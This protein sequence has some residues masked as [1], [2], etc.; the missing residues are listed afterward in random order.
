MDGSSGVAAGGGRA[1]VPEGDGSVGSVGVA[2]R[3][4]LPAGAAGVAVVPATGR[5]VMVIVAAAA[6]AALQVC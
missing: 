6:A 4:A 1:D 2:P 5:M 3:V